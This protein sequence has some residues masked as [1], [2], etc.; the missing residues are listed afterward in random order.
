MPSANVRIAQKL[1]EAI[2]GRDLDTA[3]TTI[4]APPMSTVPPRA[5]GDDSPLAMMGGMVWGVG[6]V[7]RRRFGRKHHDGDE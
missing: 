3:I 4:I 1:Y 7:I 5:S 6:T 2:N